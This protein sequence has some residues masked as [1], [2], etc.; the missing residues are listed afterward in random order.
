[1]K[2]NEKK[3]MNDEIKRING[4]NGSTETDL[5]SPNF[6]TWRYHI[7]ESPQTF[8][9]FCQFNKP[10]NQ[11]FE[12]LLIKIGQVSD[13]LMKSLVH[14]AQKQFQIK[15][16]QSLQTIDNLKITQS[17][18]SR[19]FEDHQQIQTRDIHQLLKKMKTSK[20]CCL[21]GVTEQD[22]FSD[23]RGNF[24]YGESIIGGLI[25]VISLFHLKEDI[26]SIE[27]LLNHEIGH[28][29]GLD[30]CLFFKCVM[31][32]FLSNEELINLKPSF[33]PIEQEKLQYLKKNLHCVSQI[34]NDPK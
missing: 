8:E 14:M 33:C 34:Q 29:L 32:G 9:K 16:K 18:R 3:L 11:H 30:H 6:G 1:M 23:E 17:I 12:I 4:I 7:H 19:Q 5:E 15:S 26:T 24:V 27:K 13:D 22:L 28:C 20:D 25:G 2:E 21:M 31:N 10:V